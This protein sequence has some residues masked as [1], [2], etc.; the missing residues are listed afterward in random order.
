MRVAQLLVCPIFLWFAYLQFNDPD[1]ARWIL[2]YCLVAANCAAGAL[3][4]LSTVA[5][6][7]L[8]VVL[9]AW[10]A[11][12]SMD[13]S[14]ILLKP[15]VQVLTESEETR[16]LGGLMLGALW[17]AISAGHAARKRWKEAE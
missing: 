10:A 15:S 6:L 16:E 13:I 14:D 12:L 8:T 4:R 11:V 2:V 9:V 3:N 1:A 7:V 17:C 5:C